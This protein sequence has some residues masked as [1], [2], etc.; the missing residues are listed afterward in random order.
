MAAYA[1]QARRVVQAE[2]GLLVNWA[3]STQVSGVELEL[4]GEGESCGEG[5]FM[6]L[7]QSRNLTII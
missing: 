1:V 4:V 2:E 7:V 6:P 5:V 3:V